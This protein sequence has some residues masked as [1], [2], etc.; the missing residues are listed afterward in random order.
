MPK[1]LLTLFLALSV[2]VLAQATPLAPPQPEAAASV[3]PDSADTP[4]Q[5]ALS[6]FSAESLREFRAEKTALDTLART[7]LRVISGQVTGDDARYIVASARTRCTY[8][9]HYMELPEEDGTLVGLWMVNKSSCKPL[10]G[11]R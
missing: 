7:E 11:G 9:M 2:P 4:E 8:D 6:L 3:T 1:L 5:S 10:K